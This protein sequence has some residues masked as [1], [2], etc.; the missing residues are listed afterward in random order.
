MP[1]LQLRD[2]SDSDIEALERLCDRLGGFDD[3]VTPEWLDGCMAALV[4]GPRAMTLTQWLPVLLGDAWERTFADPHDVAQATSTLL[5]RW[6]VLA[7]QLDAQ[8][9]F[10]APD[11]LRLAPLL[12]DFSAERREA[13]LAEGKIDAAQAA[14]LPRTGEVWAIGVLQAIDTFA[15]D[16]KLPDLDDDDL[17]WFDA[18][19]RSIVALTLRDDAALAAELALR[20]PGKTLDRDALVDEACFALQDLRCFWV[21]HAPRHAPRRVAPTPG[22]NDPC[23][24]GSGKKFKKCHGAADT[25]Q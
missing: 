17:A 13:L 11:E 1:T 2:S 16:W 3:R 18:S 24:C 10:D 7:S 15:D 21:E 12:D 20:Y 6:N 14:E 19:V 4:A 5:A 8:A 22:R 9:L 25:L 23:P